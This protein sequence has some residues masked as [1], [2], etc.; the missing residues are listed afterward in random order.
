MFCQVVFKR[1]AL[2]TSEQCIPYHG[3]W[4]KNIMVKIFHKLVQSK[5]YTYRLKHS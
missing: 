1:V 3:K 2:L 4:L 5:T